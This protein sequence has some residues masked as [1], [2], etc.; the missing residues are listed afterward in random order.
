M[1]RVHSRDIRCLPFLPEDAIAIVRV[2]LPMQRGGDLAA[3]VLTA[4]RYRAVG[5]ELW[6]HHRIV[7]DLHQVHAWPVKLETLAG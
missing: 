1:Q 2:A 5:S 7:L 3:Q 4:Y 6:G